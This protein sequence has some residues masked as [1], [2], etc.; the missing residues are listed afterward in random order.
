MQL[1][2][3]RRGAARRGGERCS[4]ERWGEVQ[5]GEVGRGAAGCDV[6]VTRSVM[7]GADDVQFL[8][9]WAETFTVMTQQQQNFW[10]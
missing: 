2:E 4:W 1:G 8:P 9:T 6:F 7:S 10:K 5:L 3:M